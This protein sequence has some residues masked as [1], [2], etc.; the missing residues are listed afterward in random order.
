M[1]DSAGIIESSFQGTRDVTR[2]S[3]PATADDER[4]LATVGRGDVRAAGALYDRYAPTLLGVAMRILRDR[5]DAED[6]VHDAF[7]QMTSRASQYTAERGSV[8]AWL[9]TTTRNLCIDRVRQRN[10]RHELVREAALTQAP[11]EV[12][13]PAALLVDGATREAIRGA[14]ASL[15]EEQRVTLEAIFFEGSSMPEVA[16]AQGVPLGTI[17][18]RV[19]RA[20]AKVRGAVDRLHARR[21]G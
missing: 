21:G 16:S 7:V 5:D 1:F 3:S 18:S 20:L 9:V 12:D 8:A 10:R 6:A 11:A 15:T 2:S 14:L 13:V 17:K 19:A 4:L